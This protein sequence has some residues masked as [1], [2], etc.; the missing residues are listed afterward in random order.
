M[1]LEL[2]QLSR[3]DNAASFHFQDQDTLGNLKAASFVSLQC[4]VKV[5]ARD[6]DPL[7]VYLK[8]GKL[9]KL[10]VSGPQW[11]N[12]ANQQGAFGEEPNCPQPPPRTELSLPPLGPSCRGVWSSA[13]ARKDWEAHSAAEEL[14]YRANAKAMDR[15]QQSPDS[16]PHASLSGCLSCGSIWAPGSLQ[17]PL[18]DPLLP[19]LSS[20][21]GS[22]QTF[23]Q[24]AQTSKHVLCRH[25]MLRTSSSCDVQVCYLQGL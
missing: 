8:K 19:F 16:A 4:Q 15:T 6:Q 7:A 25:P 18:L 2:N 22:G 1:L 3:D 5:R 11:L 21:P 13:Q 20:L 14:R 17:L 9:V 10:D 24:P 23:S 12:L